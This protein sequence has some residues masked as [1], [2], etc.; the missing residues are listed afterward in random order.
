[1]FWLPFF[2]HS[3]LQLFSVWL[4]GWPVISSFC[5][6]PPISTPAL[7]MYS[8]WLVGR[9]IHPPFAH[10]CASPNLEINVTPF[11][12]VTRTTL[13]M[14]S[15]MC[16]M[17]LSISYSPAIQDGGWPVPPLCKKALGY[18]ILHCPS[19]GLSVT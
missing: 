12:R 11:S 8:A 10:R 5:F 13:F 14:Y 4:V 7:S 3:T 1:M 17:A 15:L 18:P 16:A 19:S 6:R 9:Y 2:L